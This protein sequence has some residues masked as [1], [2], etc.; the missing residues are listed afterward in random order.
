MEV[1]LAK[2]AGF[3]FGVK[4]AVDTVYN[5]VGH[6]DVFTFGPIIHNEEVIQDLKN[7]GVNVIAT[8]ELLEQLENGT[9]VIPS[10]GVKKDIYD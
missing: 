4:R 1:I 8:K 7:K 6:G 9:V 3:C 5:E 2:T 10:H